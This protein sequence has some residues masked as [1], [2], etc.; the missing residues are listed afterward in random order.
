MHRCGECGSRRIRHVDHV[1]QFGYGVG[2]D[3]ATLEARVLLHAC[4]ACSFSWLDH[5]AEARMDAVVKEH[6]ATKS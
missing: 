3:A 4:D 6:L 1:E 2:A 5:V